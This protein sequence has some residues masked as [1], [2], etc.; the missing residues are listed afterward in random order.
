MYCA[1]HTT[2]TARIQC[3]NCNRGLCSSCDHR[4][5]GFPYCQDCIVAGVQSL[6]RQSTTY[7][8]QQTSQQKRS[9]SGKAI[10]AAL[11]A[12]VP[13]AGAIYNRQ[14]LK[15]V[16]HFVTIIGLFQL[17]KIHPFGAF[18]G[19]GG[20]LF[21]FYT[22]LDAFRTARAIGEGESAA[23]NEER[24][25]RSLIKRA[26]SIGLGL[27]FAGLLIFLHLIRPLSQFISFTRLAPV[28]LII[29]GGYL[30]TRYFKQSR[31]YTPDYSERQ[32]FYLVSG[33]HSE[34][35]THKV[36]DQSRFGNYR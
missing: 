16:I 20:V 19:L 8:Y 9:S 36:N 14:N 5:K 33:N 12:F 11:C 26:P 4:I 1:Y 29:L 35:E 21:Y 31:E 2:T 28:A 10:L 24:F 22:I 6:Q 3:A 18:F 15:A 30:L 27:I 23:E 32:S 7:N 13:G 34:R 17:G 25:K